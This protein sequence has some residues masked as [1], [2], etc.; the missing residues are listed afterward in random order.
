LIENNNS[1]QSLSG[2]NVESVGDD[3][4]ITSNNSMTSI[5]G[6]NRLKTISGIFYIIENE[7]L[8][9]VSELD[10]LKKTEGIIIENN[11]SLTT[12]SGA[13]QLDT[14][15][16]VLSMRY[17]HAL[18]IINGFNQLTYTG[19][20]LIE[21]VP[22]LVSVN[23]FN[24]LKRINGFLWISNNEKLNSLAGFDSLTTAYGFYIANNPSLKT[25]D[26]LSQ[27]TSLAG[28]NFNLVS[29]DSLSSIEGISNIDYSTIAYISITNSPLLSQ[30]AVK[31]ICD[32][33]DNSD[34]Y[35]CEGNA[36]GC[37]TA[38]EISDECVVSVSEISMNEI[39]FYPNPA[40]DHL[41]IN[42]RHKIQQIDFLSITG[43]KIITIYNPT[44][45]IN[46][47]FLSNGLYLIRVFNSDLELIKSEK[48]IV[49]KQ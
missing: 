24:G 27:L 1:L 38:T 35:S 7:S 34:E 49:Q 48:I 44:N 28:G 23:G 37:N 43:K 21:D 22:E 11:P 32:F 15:K 17:N 36:A 46:L 3:F 25:L 12:I 13:N 5:T 4:T 2:L 8:L 18:N 9:S 39:G 30:C 26:D 19:G 47:S 40:S 29:N 42:T 45:Q 31:S 14:S 41:F 16:W 20:V 33:I 10:S 6:L